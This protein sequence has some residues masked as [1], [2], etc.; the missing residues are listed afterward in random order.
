MIVDG[1]IIKASLLIRVHIGVSMDNVLDLLKN[2]LSP[3]L[4]S[5]VASA[6][7]ESSSNIS[8][9]LG[10]IFPMLLGGV[11]M[12]SS[13][14]NALGNIFTMLKSIPGLDSIMANP[15]NLL[16]MLTG[17]SELTKIGTQFLNT[18][19]GD[20]SQA[21]VSLLTNFAGIKVSSANALLSVA[22]P[23]VMGFLSKKITENGL[24]PT[25]F[26]SFLDSQKSNIISAAPAGLNNVLGI[27]TLNNLGAE[28][29][30]PVKD[31]GA[32]IGNEATKSKSFFKP[33]IISLLL[34]LAALFAWKFYTPR[35]DT[36][37][38]NNTADSAWP[39]LGDFFKKSLPN[40]VELNIPRLGVENKLLT[41]IEDPAT[42]VDKMAWFSFDRL[43][44]ETNSVMLKPDSQEQLKN[45]VGILKAYPKVALKLGGY[46]DNTGNSEANLKLSQERADSVRNAL[47]ALGANG[48]QLQ[49]EGYGQEHPVASNDTAEGRE[50]NRRIDVRI[51]T[52]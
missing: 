36:A 49:A 27:A 13:D 37:A 14:P 15:T 28:G 3:Q 21:A 8:T 25:S 50:Q 41:V 32:I 42:S 44:F 33:L 26:L 23:M 38:L 43:N 17:D 22:A 35:V 47:I 29:I 45:I 40:G 5:D 48:G 16:G 6:T 10:G 9:A 7:G 1:N 2:N 34:L 12:K 24:S 51:V 31:V 30:L 39:H 20:K 11:L 46:T 4:L 18:I 52:K 19:L